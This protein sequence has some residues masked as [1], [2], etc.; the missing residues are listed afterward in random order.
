[1]ATD[2]ISSTRQGILDQLLEHKSGLTVDEIIAAIGLSRTAVNQH[3]IALERRNFIRKSAPRKTGGRPVQTYVL[4]QEGTNQ[5]PKQYSWFS[6]LLV[7]TLRNELGPERLDRYMF[8]LGMATSA[9]LIPRLLG[10]TRSERITETVKIMNEA[11]FRASEIEPEGLSKLPRVECTNC[12][13]HDLTRDHPEVCR[14]DIGFLSG[15]MGTE[16][17]HQTCMQRG[18]E[19]CRFRFKPFA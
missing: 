7:S 10:K 12:V 16:V 15:L 6:A 4:T 13:Y 11:G 3:L 1:M 17:E 5:F 18:G 2:P 8:D 14:F 9:S 19:A